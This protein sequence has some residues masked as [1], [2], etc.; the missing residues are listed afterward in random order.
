MANVK[1][2]VDGFNLYYG[3]VKG[4]P[5]KWLDIAALCRRMLPNDA[6]QSI[7]YFTAIVSARPGDPGLP[8]RQQ[9][10]LRALRTIPNLTIVFGHFLTHSCR[11]VL[12][13][14]NPAQKVWV[15]KTEEKGS[16]VNI[17]AHLVRDAF[18]GRFQVAAIVTNDSDLL[19][20]VRIVRQELNLP[21]GIL[22]PDQHH[23]AALKS[24]ATFMKR[25]RQ[26]DVAA[27][28]FPTVMK[29]SK[30]QFHKPSVW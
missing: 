7:E 9:M 13:G 19:E 18:K 6:I 30:G 26:S 20:P 2:Y 27:C 22:N 4:S 17:A 24:Q 15:N 14:T 21:V 3:A 23:S 25:I 1:V 28:Q 8:V 16:D 11:M 12:T 10:Y 29:D 5:F